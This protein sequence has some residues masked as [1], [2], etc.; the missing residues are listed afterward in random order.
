MTKDKDFKQLVNNDYVDGIRVAQMIQKKRKNNTS[1]YKGVSYCKANKNWTAYLRIKGVMY[2]KN[3]FT[4]AESAYYN[5]R[6]KLEEEHFPAELVKKI[7]ERQLEYKGEKHTLFAVSYTHLTLP[8]IELECRSR[9][10]PYH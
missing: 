3:G 6:L 8:T 5:G 10:S 1:G 2:Q 9:W 7:E 4:S